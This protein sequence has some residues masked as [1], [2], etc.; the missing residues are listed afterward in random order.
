LT[1]GNKLHRKTVFPTYWETAQFPFLELMSS[2]WFR[3]P[4]MDQPM[5]G[6]GIIGWNEGVKFYPTG[7]NNMHEKNK[8]WLYFFDQVMKAGQEIRFL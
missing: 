6:K 2:E 3:S 4:Y 5:S 7:S 1:F 8:I